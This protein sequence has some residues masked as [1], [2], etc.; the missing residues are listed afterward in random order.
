MIFVILVICIALI[1]AGIVVSERYRCGG[2]VAGICMF[3]VGGFGALAAIIATICLAVNVTTLATIDDRIAMYEEENTRIEIQ[4]AEAV[5]AYQKY[6]T[7]II[8]EVKPESA[9]T[10][11]SLDPELKSD[12][13]VE[14]QI[15]VYVSNNNTIKELRDEQ[16]K[17]RAQRWWLY[18]G[19]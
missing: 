15:A 6:E 10:M 2:E 14:S 9:V 13:L 4:I 5:E 3:C 1:V 11:V 18:F 7:D 17:G 12:T 19:K 8:A 16:I